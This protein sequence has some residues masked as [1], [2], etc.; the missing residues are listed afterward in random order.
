[1]TNPHSARTH[2]Q[3]SASA[4][5]RNVVCAGAI[6]ME[7]LC[8]ERESEAAAWG[9]LA[10]EISD[11]C[12]RSGDDANYFLGKTR[13]VGKFEFTV[14]EEMCAT[15]QT[16]VDYCV[17][18][19][20]DYHAA[21]DEE[22]L[23]WVETNFSLSKLNPP[24]EAGG[25]GDCVIYFPRWKM[26]E[27]VDLKGGRGVVVEAKKNPQARTYGLGA[28][29]TFNNLDV[30]IV[31]STIVQP[32][33]SHADGVIRFEEIHVSELIEWSAQLLKSMLRS[34]EALDAF[35]QVGDN[36]VKFEEWAERYLTVGQCL[37]C[38]PKAICP[39]ARQDA[40]KILDDKARIWFEEPGETSTPVVGNNPKLAS[41][42][43]LGHWLDGLEALESW[44]KDV[45]GHAHAQVEAGTIQIPGWQLADKIGNRTFIE[46]DE[47]KLAKQIKE[48]LK[49]DDEIVYEPK[50]VRSV[51]Q[52][53]KALG[54]RKSELA[55][56]ENV[57]WHKPKKGTNLVEAEKTTREPAQTRP[58][59]Y[60]E[61]VETEKMENG[62]Q[63]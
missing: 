59:R 62:K 39:K 40:L 42:E 33:A 29:L 11:T 47:V 30:E 54:K 15:A 1:M 38:P 61:T 41:S 2:T 24:I 25:T 14:D 52:L 19:I 44:I 60:F 7:T 56:L 32:R 63:S 21:T 34:R 43:E 20:A 49:V 35:K 53:E 45:R 55:A 51:A 9:T 8:E 26:I 4:T 6:A 17:A 50:S 36:R 27:I 31:R 16:Y 23:W 13:K 37:F 10:H 58:E 48:K 12:L 18:R 3:W 28:M 22:A 5:S 46:K 57:L